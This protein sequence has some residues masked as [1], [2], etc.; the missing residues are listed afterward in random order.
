MNKLV[1][2]YEQ[3]YLI[4]KVEDVIIENYCDNEMK[5]PMHMSR[6]SEAIGV[7]VY[8]ALRDRGQYFSTY[9]SHAPYLASGGDLNKFFAEIYGKKEGMYAGKAGSMHIASPETGHMSS[10]AIVA[11]NIPVAIGAAWANKMQNNGKIVVV[12]F[13]DGAMDEGNFWESINMASL[14]GLPILFVCEDNRVAVHTPKQERQGYK[15]IISL[16]EEFNFATTYNL[17]LDVEEVYRDVENIIMCMNKFVEPAFMQL[18]YYRYLEHVGVNADTSEEYRKADP[19][20][21]SDDNDP[22]FLARKKLIDAKVNV[23]SI[24]QSI[25]IK[26]YKALEFA[27]NGVFSDI[28]ETYKDVFYD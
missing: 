1:E 14:W 9:R 24:E 18:E 21:P 12:F 11:S 23:L 17:G 2:F 5:T 8:S 16:M 7:G 27:K 6:G 10:S 4:R 26:V 19:W 20:I 25:N 13:G 3:M 22:I 15:N 28:S